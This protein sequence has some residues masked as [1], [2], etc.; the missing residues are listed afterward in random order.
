MNFVTLQVNKGG[1]EKN[2]YDSTETTLPDRDTD[3][4]GNPWKG[5][6]VYRQDGVCLQNDAF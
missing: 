3:F 2:R 4:L 6:F 5:L 1:K